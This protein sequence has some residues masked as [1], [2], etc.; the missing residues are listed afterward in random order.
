LVTV[1]FKITLTNNGS[2][3]GEVRL[4]GLPFT[5][6]VTMP[7]AGSCETAYVNYSG[8]SVGNIGIY[9]TS[10][11]TYFRPRYTHDNSAAAMIQC[12][13]VADNGGF[14]GMFSYTTDS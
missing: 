5:P 12:S 10:S 4:T 3:G 11:Q 6:N 2:W 13:E 14:I 7:H 9:I 1:Q 8:G